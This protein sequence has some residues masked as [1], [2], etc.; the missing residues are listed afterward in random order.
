MKSH[1]VSAII[2]MNSSAVLNGDELDDEL[3]QLEKFAGIGYENNRTQIDL[4]LDISDEK[5]ENDLAKDSP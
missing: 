4:E 1:N 5:S 3:D 2:P